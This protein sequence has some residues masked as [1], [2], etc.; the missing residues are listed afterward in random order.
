MAPQNFQSD[1][2]LSYDSGGR[3]SSK[4]NAACWLSRA[5]KGTRRLLKKELLGP[6]FY[7]GEEFCA[8]ALK[9]IK[10]NK[11]FPKT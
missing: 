1:W 3:P 6:I 2:T 11:K 4:P 7:L 10:S 9:T 5:H 8:Q